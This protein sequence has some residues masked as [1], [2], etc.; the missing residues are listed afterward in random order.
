MSTVAI[1]SDSE[2]HGREKKYLTRDLIIKKPLEPFALVGW[3][4][5]LLSE[6]EVYANRIGMMEGN[7]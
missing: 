6:E 5:Q 2:A 7:F 4:E 1:I 3:T